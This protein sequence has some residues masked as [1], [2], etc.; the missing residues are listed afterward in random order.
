MRNDDATL[1]NNV[2]SEY[3]YSNRDGR[4]SNREW[5]FDQAAIREMD[6]DSTFYN[7][8]ELLSLKIFSMRKKKIQRTTIEILQRGP[9]FSK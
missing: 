7:H 2:S 6:H 5:I 9:L 1:K 4:R 8:F 3:N